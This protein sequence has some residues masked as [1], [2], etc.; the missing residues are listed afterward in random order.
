[1]RRLFLLF[2][3]T[4]MLFCCSSCR[5]SQ[6]VI[7]NEQT[8]EIYFVDADMLRLLPFSVRLTDH[9]AQKNAQRVVGELIKG[10]DDNPKIMRLIPNVKNVMT[11]KVKNDTAYVN[12]TKKFVDE[13]PDGKDK[14]I[15]TV[16]SIVNS[17][18]SVN[19]ITK[20][21]FTIDGKEQERFKGYIDMRE[22]F[23]PDYTV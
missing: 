21:K 6:A 4:S 13:H 16:Y 12:L 23:T 17:L 7:A 5:E 11:V 10:K 3:A 1:M 18:T 2:M 15:L 19:G 22:T 14:E 8:A 20:V 9:S